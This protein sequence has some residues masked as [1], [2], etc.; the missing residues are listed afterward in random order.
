MRA[1][2][3]ACVYV[4]VCMCV[5]VCVCVCVQWHLGMYKQAYTP[6]HRG[7]DEHMGVYPVAVQLACLTGAPSVQ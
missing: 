6:A 7:F 4:C 2:V 5:C 3:R 1:C